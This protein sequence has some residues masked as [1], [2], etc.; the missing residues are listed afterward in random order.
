MTLV[1]SSPG[2]R[3]L[4]QSGPAGIVRPH[5][6]GYDVD[7]DDEHELNSAA[8]GPGWRARE[9]RVDS[10]QA[11]KAV[12]DRLEWARRGDGAGKD[13]ADFGISTA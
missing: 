1:Q 11:A 3:T 8:R 13:G 9:G 10:A 4:T 7:I 2:A 12:H 6:L 5:Q